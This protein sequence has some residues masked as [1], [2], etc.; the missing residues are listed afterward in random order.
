MDNY[1][2]EVAE[3]KIREK[4]NTD[5][6]KL[7]LPPYTTAENQQGEMP[8]DL[9]KKYAADLM[10]SEDSV[11]QILEDLRK[12]ALAKLAERNKFQASGIATLKIK[13]ASKVGKLTKQI[14]SVEISLD[15]TGAELKRIAA[16][17]AEVD[18]RHLKLIASGKVISDK[19]PLKLQ[20]IKNGSQV[21]LVVLSGH[22]VAYMDHHDEEVS[23]VSKTREAA[24]LLSSRAEEED[25][26]F[27]VQIA[28][29]KGRPLALPKHEKKSLTLAMALHEKGRLA[30]KQ[31]HYSQALLLLLEADKSFGACSAEIMASVDNYAILNLDIV[32]CYLCLENIRELPD[33]DKRLQKCE[34]MFHR[35]YGQYM[36][37]LTIIKGGA[38]AERILM[39][40]L[41]LLKGIVAFHQHNVSAADHLLQQA[42]DEYFMLQVDPEAVTHLVE[43]GFTIREARLGLR[44]NQ[45]NVEK[46]AEY[47]MKDRQDKEEI[48]QKIKKDREERQKAKKYGLCA[49]GESLNMSNV[50][51]L[52]NM[53][54]PKKAAI[55]AL[56]KANNDIDQ[57]LEL[58]KTHP[59]LMETDSANISPIQLSD[60][61]IAQLVEL[62][63]E[64]EMVI[65]ALHKHGGDTSKAAEDL[66]KYG[67]V[68]P[69][70]SDESYSED[71]TPSTS[72]ESSPDKR[73]QQQR[74]EENKVI[75]ELVSDLPQEED[76]HLDFDMN[77]EKQFL[78][79][80]MALIQSLK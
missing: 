42:K 52:V 69:N 63:F 33:A 49:N 47:I 5:K 57:A 31:K 36:E 64:P 28:D 46:A 68:L 75:D 41:H 54:Y 25:D 9:I 35:S 4:L 6:V 22:E 43:I 79:H 2:Q 14:I 70:S 51:L 30:L 23:A 26:A 15:K 21:M 24:E 7:W 73:Q 17:E 60:K 50:G 48:R 67:G 3:A 8:K 18:L 40:R 71:S 74:Q 1:G 39:M 20:N 56:K 65:T 55:K 45:G 27:D 78:D 10:L 32:W 11:S 76:E 13:V 72:S 37:R 61:D 12:H 66:I 38:D 80:Y 62:G 53:Q 77:D 29:Q 44:T 19:D 16:E 59:E 34:E 58:L